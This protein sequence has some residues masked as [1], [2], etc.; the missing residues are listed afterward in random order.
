LAGRKGQDSI[1]AKSQYLGRYPNK[2]DMNLKTFC[3][4]SLFFLLLAVPFFVSAQKA[5]IVPHQLRCE[6][7]ENP[8]GLDE[9]IPRFNW[10]L[11]AS[12]TL[13]RGQAQAAYRI[14]VAS[15]AS[16][17]KA[18][19]GDV[20]DSGWLNSSE[21]QLINYAGKSLLSDKSYYW[22]VAVKD[23]KGRVSAWSEPASWSTGLFNNSDW[24]A[25]WIGTA[26]IFDPKQ[27]DCNVVDPW[28]RKSFSLKSKPGRAMFFV[29]SVGYHE[30]YVNGK[31][32]GNDVLSPGVSDHS[33]R[34]RYVA[35]DIAPELK[36]GK[37]VIAIWLGASWSIFG[38]YNTKERP[39]TPIVIA[40]TSI[41]GNLVVTDESWKTHDSPNKLL[42]VWDF[43]RMGGEVWDAGKEIANW[44]TTDCDE[45]NWKPAVVYQPNLVLSA[46]RIEPNRLFEEIKPK[47][48]VARPDG[49]YRVDMGVNFAG[50]TSVNVSG[51]P[52][53]KIEF[54]YS[55]RAQNDMT[56][57]LHSA[58]IIG[59][60]GKGTFK[61]KFNYSSGRWI[62]IKGLKNKPALTDIK[63]WMART[64]FATASRF[65]CADTLQNWIYNTVNWT[66]ENLSLGGYVV[67]CPQ[68]ERLGYGGDAHAT[69]ETG[70]LNY[71]MGAF[72][73]KWMEDWRDVQGSEA[74]V[75]NMHDPN[76]ARKG[77]MSG[78]PLHP[79]ILPHSAPTYMGGGGPAWGG[80]N[81][82]LPW[83]F[84]QHYGDRTILVKNFE[85]ISKWLEFLDTQT[86]DDMLVRFGGDWDFLGDWLWP[87]ATAE[88]M[89]NNKPQTLFLNNC[90]RVFNLR[91]AA[92]IARVVGNSAA[93]KKWEQQA[94]VSSAA[95]HA[96]Y[97]NADDHSYSD[98]SMANLAAALLAEIMPP[99]LK[100]LVMNRLEKEILEVRKGHINVGITG[101]A[102]LFKVLRESGRDDL[103]YSMTSQTTYPSWGYMK[104]ND[105][106]TIWE[107]WEKDLPGHSLLHS[108]YL[109]PGAWYIDGLAG[110]KRDDSYPGYNRFI[111]RPP[112][113]SANQMK[114]AKADMQSPSGL[115]RT[116][117][118]REAGKLVYKITVPPNCTA[119]LQIPVAEVGNA[120][121]D[122][123][124]VRNVGAKDGFE[125]FQ[126]SA[127]SYNLTFD[128]GRTR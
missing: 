29:A 37:N 33:K 70:M 27:P 5:S 112:S 77:I 11:K 126:L 39:N 6:Y 35:Y 9:P 122:I 23:E 66:L 81:V 45:T 98:K 47:E 40:Q 74:V 64:N 85:M 67:D 87:G 36:K 95:I 116:M 34:A 93:A 119:T 10:T 89:N 31:K 4:H 123:K 86:K 90:Y 110:I 88:G 79:G 118:K 1:Y 109:Y 8:A 105:A 60:S 115:I 53:D 61:N 42:G 21:M 32:I 16:T 82:S 127:G 108:S 94:K 128:S 20:W 91:T 30:V 76:F 50:W 121:G 7:L 101:G 55:E 52:G 3:C 104:E 51:N 103:I 25:K 75:G 84:F 22:K 41:N 13:A 113:L 59:A 111:L 120:S 54:L 71:H 99:D 56:F 96:K 107:M 26:Q 114:W 14:L 100:A 17:L 24:K 19:K 18:N 106:T 43:G 58:F 124:H 57:S 28:L 102:M 83:F 63:G 49:S 117:W 62:T 68:R 15:N 97:Y 38:P 44:N 80:I 73:T 92:K 12:D 125:Q 69:C 72:Y 2:P 65:E 46:E 78:R 48:I